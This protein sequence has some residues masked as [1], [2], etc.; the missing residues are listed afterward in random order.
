MT[1]KK[2]CVLSTG[3]RIDTGI[4][5]QRT[6]ISKQAAWVR[7]KKFQNGSISEH[8]LLKPKSGRGLKKYVLQ[9]THIDGE[10][11]TVERVAEIAEIDNSIA[12]LRIEKMLRGEILFDELL[13]CQYKR[14]DH[15]TSDKY[16]LGRLTPEQRDTIQEFADVFSDPRQRELLEKYCG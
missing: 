12:F 7:I 4:I 1:P 8:D 10:V 2:S 11:Y 16:F 6:G 9:Y 14:Y 5:R 15:N 13:S 3:E